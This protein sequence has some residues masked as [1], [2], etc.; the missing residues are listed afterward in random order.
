MG[1]LLY[2]AGYR[3]RVVDVRFLPFFQFFAVAG[4][5][6][7]LEYLAGPRRTSMGRAAAAMLAI[8]AVLGGLAWADSRITFV[9]K[10]VRGNMVGFENKALW[11]EY[12]A[13]CDRIAG[14]PADP[15]VAYEHSGIHWH[16]GTIRAFENLPL[17]SGRSTLEGV[18][19]QAS[20]TAPFIFHTQSEMSRVASTP[21][22]DYFYSRFRPDR[23]ARH[24]AM[25]NAELFIA[26]EPETKQ[27]LAASP[28]FNHRF[29]SGP[30]DVFR[31]PGVSGRYVEPL[32]R[33]PVRLPE[34]NWRQTAYRWFR[35][36]DMDTIPVFCDDS[37]SGADPRFASM[38]AGGGFALPLPV[39]PLPRIDTGAMREEISQ[40]EIRVTGATPGRPLLVK[41]SH[42]PNWRVEGADRIYLAG[43]GFMLIFPDRPDVRLV[44]GPGAAK[45]V[46]W[47]LTL[48]AVLLALA[49]GLP[50]VAGRLAGLAAWFDRRAWI[51]VIVLLAVFA[52]GLGWFLGPASPEFPTTPFNEAIA[53]FRE[54]DYAAG[55]QRFAYVLERHPQSLIAG[56]AAYHLAMC[57]Y[58]MEQWDQAVE[59]LD[60]LMEEYPESSRHAEALY[61]KGLCLD[62]AGVP[63]KAVRAWQRTVREFPG[64]VWADFSRDR[65]AEKDRAVPDGG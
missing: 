30:Y 34:E 46:G 15:R 37:D 62:R 29:S 59:A 43:P 3:A 18:Y 28:H 17:F 55:K 47:A 54:K 38:P 41:V 36:G 6:L 26:A 56:E 9:D 10:W 2:L 16:A 58:R 25:F 8:A 31:L 14:G 53:M 13:L 42:H 44:Y 22:P 24:L 5:A 1:I 19:I 50:A 65:L 35:L 21:I 12:R 11:P 33:R 63:E 27:A 4:G 45:C 23:G 39:E 57:D 64:S 48:A 61:H 40:E 20:P 51:L 49:F 7:L 32:S 60:R 52:A